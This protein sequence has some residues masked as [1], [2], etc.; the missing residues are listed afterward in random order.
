MEKSTPFLI[1]VTGWS[2]S[3]KTTFCERLITELISRGY[4]TAAAKNTH[5]EL[6]LDKPGSDSSRFSRNGAQA[7]CLNAANSM[8]VFYQTPLDGGKGLIELFKGYDFIVA[9]G[10]KTGAAIRIEI[11]GTISEP[12]EMKK[13]FIRHRSLNLRE[14]RTS[15]PGFMKSMREKKVQSSCSGMISPQLRILY[16]AGLDIATAFR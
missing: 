3:G 13:S 7:V 2:G 5:E 10:F 14:S 1:S 11:T 12:E 9:E 4:K 6:Q 15:P 16:A 8:A